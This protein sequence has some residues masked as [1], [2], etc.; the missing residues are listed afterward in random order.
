MVRLSPLFISAA[1]LALSAPAFAQ[2]TDYPM[3]KTYSSVE[4]AIAASS[5]IP[6]VNYTPVYSD[7]AIVTETPIMDVEIFDTPLPAT[8]GKVIAAANTTYTYESPTATYTSSYTPAASAA[9]LHNVV[10]DDTLYNIAT[11]NGIKV[12]EL[13]NANNLTSSAISIGQSLT[14]PGAVAT[15]YVETPVA[16]PVITQAAQ[17]I[18]TVT[19]IPGATNIYRV[20][21][22]DTL[23]SISR[24]TCSSVMGIASAS[25]IARGGILSPGQALTLP[26]GHCAN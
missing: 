10:K 23:S 3:A 17:V 1:A 13:M 14:I 26:E 16:S 4:E 15:S 9:S 6:A 24:S 19:A 12:S 2:A 5:L 20:L 8:Q 7:S 21:P 18:R 11:R 25:G 22:G